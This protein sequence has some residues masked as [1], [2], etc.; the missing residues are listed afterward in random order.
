MPLI[1]IQPP[2]PTLFCP[3]LVAT[4]PVRLFQAAPGR[5]ATI[6]A[7]SHSLDG[8]RPPLMDCGFVARL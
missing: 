4:R 2:P 8:L 3:V 1:S 7:R 6:L 5:R